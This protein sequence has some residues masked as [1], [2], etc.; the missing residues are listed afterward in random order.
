MIKYIKRLGL[1]Y[2]KKNEAIKMT[3]ITMISIAIATG[4]V[5]GWDTLVSF[6]ISKLA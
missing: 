4:C 1:T 3:I 5:F 2:P 6:A